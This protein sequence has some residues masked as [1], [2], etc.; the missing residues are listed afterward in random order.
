MKISFLSPAGCASHLQDWPWKKNAWE[1]LKTIVMHIILNGA[2]AAICW[3]LVPK[4]SQ[5]AFR[6]VPLY[7]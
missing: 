7:F 5:L 2:L 6:T 4:I 3:K 1:A